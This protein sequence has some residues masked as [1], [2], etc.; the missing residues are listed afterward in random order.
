M[1]FDRRGFIVKNTVITCAPDDQAAVYG[2]KKRYQ[3]PNLLVFGSIKAMTSSGT[4]GIEGGGV[5]NGTRKAVLSDRSI[6][7]DIA[8]IGRHPLGIGIYLFE[9]KLEFRDTCG[10]GRHF[11]AMAD[12][13]EA[14][15]PE[16]V[17]VHPNGY[18]QVDYAMLGIYQGQ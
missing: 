8:E 4:T 7:Q 18:K 10:H 14:V 5:G 1:L 3:K 13:V 9:Y 12:E 2:S 11:G 17:S 6:K 16:A 15:M